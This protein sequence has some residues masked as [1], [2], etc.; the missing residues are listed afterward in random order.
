MIGKDIFLEICKF[1]KAKEILKFSF[2]EKYFYKIWDDD[3]KEKY[4]KK[5]NFVVNNYHKKIIKMF[6]LENLLDYPIL[7]WEDKYLGSTDY[8]DC[9]FKNDTNNSIMIGIDKYRRPFITIKITDGKKI[10]VNTLFQRY[11]NRSYPIVF[12]TCYHYNIHKTLLKE[13]EIEIYDKII[14]GNS[15]N[16]NNYTLSLSK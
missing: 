6:N 10:S 2:V 12:G 4:L 9:I 3:F 11:S 14:K 5:K 7:K 15:V 8:I 1:L 13:E 16:S